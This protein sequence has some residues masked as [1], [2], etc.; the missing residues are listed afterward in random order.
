MF[1]RGPG[2]RSSAAGGA[3]TG[4]GVLSALV[5]AWG[6]DL[7]RAIT[8]LARSRSVSSWKLEHNFSNIG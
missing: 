2:A 1:G 4:L 5:A 8:V 7:N 3:T 6:A